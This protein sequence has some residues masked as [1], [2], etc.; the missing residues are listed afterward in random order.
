VA[1]LVVTLLDALTYSSKVIETLVNNTARWFSVFSRRN[2]PNLFTKQEILKH[3]Q[4]FYGA[5]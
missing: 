3:T 5:T 4:C 1:Q 2:V